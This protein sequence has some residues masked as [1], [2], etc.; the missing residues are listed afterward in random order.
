MN[1]GD[2]A[3]DANATHRRFEEPFALGMHRKGRAFETLRAG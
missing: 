3:A 1:Q 2:V